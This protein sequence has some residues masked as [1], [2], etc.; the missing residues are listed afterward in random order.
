MVVSFSSCSSDSISEEIQEQELVVSSNKVLEQAV[1]DE[2]NNFRIEKGL[3]PLTISDEAYPYAMQ[4][5]QF[6]I[7]TGSLSHNAFQD[8]ASQLSAVSKATKVAENVAKGYTTAQTVVDAWIASEGHYVNMIGDFS[9]TAICIGSDQ[10]GVLY[11][12]QIFFQK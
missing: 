4:Q 10:D 7:R 3:S 2:V 11:Y 8:R 12:T 6:M 1:F 9:H 5:T